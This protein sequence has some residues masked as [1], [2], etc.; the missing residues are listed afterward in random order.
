MTTPNEPA[1]QLESWQ[2]I[3]DYLGVSVRTAQKWEIERGLPVSRQRD[4]RG[5]VS[6][7][8]ADLDKWR[9][10]TAE[11]PSFWDNLRLLR[12]YAG[13]TAGTLLL[14]LCVAAGYF[15]HTAGAGHPARLSQESDSVI[16]ADERGRELW[17]YKFE[18]P[19]R[20]EEDQEEIPTARRASF[21]DLDGDGRIETLYA[22]VPAS[23]E[24]KG[25]SLLC[26][27]EAGKLRWSFRSGRTVHTD[28]ATFDP[29]Y[30]ISYFGVLPGG[31]R[32]DARILVVSNDFDG[33]PAQVVVLDREGRTLGEYWHS[34]PLTTVE[35]GDLDSDGVPEIILG[36]YSSSYQ[37]ATLVVL[38]SRHVQGASTERE[39]PKFQI[40][41]FGPGREKARLLFPRTGVSR[42]LEARNFVSQ[43]VLRF[44]YLR[45]E[46]RER[47]E[48]TATPPQAGVV[49]ALDRRLRVMAVEATDEFWAQRRQLE[50]LRKLGPGLEDV[51]I[52]RLG[53]S[54]RALVNSW[55]G[56]P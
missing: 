50:S 37:A 20:L 52:K 48:G 34:G 25:A 41:G 40:L 23:I 26:F 3:A 2:S 27:S 36:G 39:S 55:E 19:L 53:G 31:N 1:P 11:R 29:P 35:T 7:D 46:V 17:R 51:D 5:K 32:G 4:A 45:L 43:I 30:A 33:F 44:G 8:P 22:Y 18:D 24:E 49:Y 56:R 9:E 38:D 42:L 54:V 28:G 16:V 12:T 6:A 10:A 47:N 15:I 13:I 21:E 14:E